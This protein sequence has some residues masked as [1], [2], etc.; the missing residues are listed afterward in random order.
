MNLNW[1]CKTK[2]EDSKEKIVTLFIDSNS[3]GLHLKKKSFA[4]FVHPWFEIFCSTL[5]M[6]QKQNGRVSHTKENVTLI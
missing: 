5:K 3:Y 1:T 4:V 6:G 2:T